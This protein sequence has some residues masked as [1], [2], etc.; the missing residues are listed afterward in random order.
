MRRRGPGAGAWRRRRRC[1]PS[2]CAP[3]HRPRSAWPGRWPRRRP[4]PWAWN[5]ASMSI[6]RLSGSRIEER[7]SESDV[8]HADGQ[9]RAH[10]HLLPSIARAEKAA[11][12]RFG[13]A[14]LGAPAAAPRIERAHPIAQRLLTLLVEGLANPVADLAVDVRDQREAR[15][16]LEPTPVL[17]G[18]AWSA[19]TGRP[20]PPGALPSTRS[21]EPDGSHSRPRERGSGRDHR[22]WP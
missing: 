15:S 17:G 7:V 12:M 22:G 11:A 1:V 2:R 19:R 13:S 4:F 3:W 16:I 9:G 14:S 18:A 21:G 5:P 20:S 8:V 10:R 6:V